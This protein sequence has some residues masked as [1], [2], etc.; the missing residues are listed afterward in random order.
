MFKFFAYLFLPV[1]KGVAE[2]IK[3]RKAL[4]NICVTSILFKSMNC[5]SLNATFKK[6]EI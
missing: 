1:C 2:F 3:S 4:F 6:A 5:L